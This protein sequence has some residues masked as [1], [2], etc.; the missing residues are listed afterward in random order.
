MGGLPGCRARRGRRER[1]RATKI[2]SPWV[3]APEESW[4]KPN[5]CRLLDLGRIDAHRPDV[6]RFAGLDGDGRAPG[7]LRVDVA[8]PLLPEHQ[9]LLAGGD[10]LDLERSVLV[11]DREERMI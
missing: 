1:R 5:S 4:S 8:D 2:G 10:A 7:L 11:R 9:V 3:R 6:G